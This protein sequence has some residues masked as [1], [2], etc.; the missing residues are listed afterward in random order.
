MKLLRGDTTANGITID[1]GVQVLH[2]GEPGVIVIAP[3]TVAP[4]RLFVPR[5]PG[6]QWKDK[7]RDLGTAVTYTNNVVTYGDAATPHP[8]GGILVIKEAPLVPN[9]DP[10]TF[11]D[12]L[13]YS[14]KYA[15]M[16]GGS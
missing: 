10:S 16:Y 8:R 4:C 6:G 2:N 3:G 5:G 12:Y 11:V 9:E 1:D 7:W 13:A 14:D 15:Q